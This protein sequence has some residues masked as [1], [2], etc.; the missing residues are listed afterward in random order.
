M[1]AVDSLNFAFVKNFVKSLALYEEGLA[2]LL[3]TIFV[4]VL[5]SL[6]VKVVE[7]FIE[8]DKIRQKY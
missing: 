3:P 8:V 2:W 4:L 5:T 1:D 6:V 7:S